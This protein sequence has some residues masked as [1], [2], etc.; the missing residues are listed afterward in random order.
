MIF[1]VDPVL[2][3]LRAKNRAPGMDAHGTSEDI[4]PTLDPANPLSSIKNVGSQV[5]ITKLAYILQKQSAKAANKRL[6]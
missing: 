4:N 1:F 3:A 6:F 2:S 5:M